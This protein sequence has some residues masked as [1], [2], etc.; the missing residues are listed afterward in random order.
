MQSLKKRVAVGTAKNLF[1]TQV[2]TLN[3]NKIN[4]ITKPT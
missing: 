2:T 3:Y 4:I 1:T